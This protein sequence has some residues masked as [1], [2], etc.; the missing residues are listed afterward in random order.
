MIHRLFDQ[1][2]WLLTYEAGIMPAM[3]RQA[4]RCRGIR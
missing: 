1:I 2:M 4:R 3:N